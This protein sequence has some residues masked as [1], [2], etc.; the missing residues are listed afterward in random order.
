V[1]WIFDLDE[2]LYNEKDFVYSGLQ[3]VAREVTKNSEIDQNQIF[4]F[5]CNEFESRGRDNVFQTLK[6]E[7]QSIQYRVDELIEVYRAHIPDIKLYDDAQQLL[8]HLEYEKKY[9]VTDGNK[10]TQRSKI[11]ALNIQRN[12]E[13]IYV[14]DEH[15]DG[16]PKPGLKCFQMIKSKE[17]CQWEDMVYIG[18]DPHKDFVSLKAIGAHTIRVNRGR[19]Q[20]VI[21]DQEHEAGITVQNLKEL[22]VVF[23]QE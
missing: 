22:F 20:N 6:A 18:D 4:Q 3:A 14:T 15:G 7:F 23:S 12:F 2:T 5:M 10:V 13:E 21:L 1:I 11:S 17:N 8:K 19:L 16:A 9:L